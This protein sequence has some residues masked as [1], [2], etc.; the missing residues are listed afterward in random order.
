[1]SSVLVKLET[2]TIFS[3]VKVDRVL[4]N[5]FSTTNLPESRLLGI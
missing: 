3:D 1:M 2:R 5:C 4:R